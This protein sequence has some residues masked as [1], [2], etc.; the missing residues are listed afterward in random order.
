MRS[1]PLTNKGDESKMRQ[2]KRICAGVVLTL[3]FAFSTFA[4]QMPCPGIADPPPP[5]AASATT[6]ND[7]EMSAGVV[8]ILATFLCSVF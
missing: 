6:E 8:E 4:G 5:Q 2:L 3:A 7:G 1:N